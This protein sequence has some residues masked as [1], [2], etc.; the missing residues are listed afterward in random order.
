[1]RL[2]EFIRQNLEGILQQWEDFARSLKPEVAMSID[3]LR[4]DA[5]QMLRFI[6]ADIESE[7]TQN[8]ELAKATGRGPATPLG[9]LS[10]AH[11]HGISRAVE[12]FSLIELV[13]EYRALRASVT[14][15]WIEAEPLTH[16]TV[17]QLVRFNEAMDQILAEGVAKFTERMDRDADLF[18]ASVGHDLANP[19]DAVTTSVHLLAASHTL[20]ANERAAVRRITRAASRLSGMLDDLRDFTRTRLGGLVRIDRELCDVGDLV[21]DIVDELTA[22]YVGRKLVA[23]CRGDLAAHVDVRRVSQMVSNLVAN[24]LQ[25]GG[26]TTRVTVSVHGDA[27]TVTID[28]HNTEAVIEPQRLR[29]LFEPLSRLPADTDRSRLGLGLYIVQQIAFAH[30]GTINVTSTDTTGTRFTV[31]LPRH[32]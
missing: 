22:I 4:D 5:E 13:S 7:Q 19:V 27:D 15:M 12:R 10:A 9:T 30:N 24:A 18:T 6:M 2:S 17:A 8:Q 1:M 20:S 11:E 32:G 29:R 26:E 14:R 21:R 16:D 25:H 3:A 23:E 31:R 28:V